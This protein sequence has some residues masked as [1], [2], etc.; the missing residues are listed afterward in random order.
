M[1]AVLIEADPEVFSRR[2][3]DFLRGRPVDNTLALTVLDAVLH[4]GYPEHLLASLADDQGR[5]AAVGVQ[6]PPR[7]MIVAAE[8]PAAAAAL[9]ADLRAA[10]VAVPGVIGMAPAAA[11]FA[12]SWRDAGSGAHRVLTEEPL[13]RLDDLIPPRPAPGRFRVCGPDDIDVIARW[14]GEFEREADTTGRTDDLIDAA[15]RAIGDGRRFVWEADGAPVAFAGRSRLIAGT[16]R[17]GPVYTPP[18]LRG[19]GYAGNLV[20]ALSTQIMADGGVPVLFTDGSYPVSNR[21]YRSLGFVQVGDA[22][23][24]GFDERPA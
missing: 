8:E 1:V 13:F 21:L 22:V 6:T 15:R 19:R 18:E 23:E 3:G 9:A 7:F 24:I 5:I 10:G 14:S 11:A 20:A 2:T 4:N 16:A 17:I 12:A